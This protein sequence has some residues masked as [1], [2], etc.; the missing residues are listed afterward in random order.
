MY[1]PP[2]RNDNVYE[3][4]CKY[5][6]FYNPA[7]KHY[8]TENAN[9]VCDKCK[10]NNLTICIGYQNYDL[11]LSCVQNIC[12]NEN[13]FPHKFKPVPIP[14]YEIPRPMPSYIDDI[15]KPVPSSYIEIASDKSKTDEVPTAF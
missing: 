3:Q 9:V 10:K 7:S 8:N 12:D 6:T 1:I 5:G 11:C 2:N 15:S 14:N 4:I 13:V